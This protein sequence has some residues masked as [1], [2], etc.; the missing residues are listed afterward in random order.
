MKITFDQIK[1]K[2][3]VKGICIECGKKKSRIL[4]EEQTVNPFN[5]NEDGTPKS[6]QEVIQAV[7]KALAEKVRKYSEN[8]ICSSC[9][10][11]A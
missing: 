8:F 10:Q 3:G 2:Q 1:D 6:R 11:Y 5:K 9:K 4:T 7:E